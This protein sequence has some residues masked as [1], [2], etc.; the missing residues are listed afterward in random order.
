MMPDKSSPSARV[1]WVVD[2]D[3]TTLMLAEEVLNQ[4]G[5]EVR[6]F[7]SASSALAIARTTLPDIVVV[8]VVMPGM[9]GFEFCRHLRALPAAALIPILVTTSLDDTASIDRAYQAG[10]TNFATK[11]INWTIEIQRLHYLLKSAA[12]ARE[13]Q[14]KEL[15]TRAAKEDWELTFNSITDV[16]LVLDLNMRVLRANEAAIQLAGQPWE[17]MKGQYCRDLFQCLNQADEECLSVWSPTRLQSLVSEIHCGKNGASYEV[18]ISP[19]INP[20]GMVT[21]LVK[22]ARD[23]TTQKLLEGEL[24]QA[25][26]MEA[27]GTL[28]GGIA[29]DFN[30][31]LTVVQCCAQMLIDNQAVQ[32]TA[33][34]E[35]QAILEAA[36]RGT[37]LAKQLLVFSRK[38]VPLGQKQ[39]VD[40]NETLRSVWK[41]LERGLPKTLTLQKRLGANLPKVHADNGHLEQV[42]MNLAVN[43]GHAM[44]PGGTL[45]IET[46]NET[47]GADFCRVHPDARPGDYVLLTVTD[48]G[49]GMDKQTMERIY[50]PF[51]TTKEVGQGTGLGL[52]VVFGIVQEHDGFLTCESA[53]GVGTT[54][55]IYL[56]V[57]SQLELPIQPVAEPKAA[58]PG[59]TETLLIVDDEAPIRRLLER[60]LGRLGYHILTAMDGEMALRRYAEATEAGNRPQ[61]VIMDL[62]MPH[63]SGWVCLEKLRQFDSQAKV[64]VATGYGD[65][66]MENRVLEHGAL[67]FM[68]K[69]YNLNDVA[70]KLREVLD[71]SHNPK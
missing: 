54:F 36:K 39:L 11:P 47:L 15:E 32:E 21:R 1:V 14:Q 8:D 55:G 18:T 4:A 57:A 60:H 49:H 38:E 63:M 69:P 28:A 46:K 33:T 13:L 48:T 9:D 62:G 16:V 19:V 50:E 41:M 23:L 30:N 58:L 20:Q 17:S 35:L 12:L 24:R 37:T 59:G 10:A 71:L 2:D 61:L 5:F 64:V 52:S 34:E 51:F 3:E 25:Q 42:I 31:L 6:T 22:I 26:K 67:G 66:T 45:R 44:A 7:V 65:P 40:L 43:A 27:I 70:K 68:S 29:H 53:P 56:P